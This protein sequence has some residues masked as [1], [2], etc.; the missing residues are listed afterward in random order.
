MTV[1]VEAAVSKSTGQCGG[2]SVAAE[3]LPW[4]GGGGGGE[5]QQQRWL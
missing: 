5:Y 4:H 3:A 1:A 2:G